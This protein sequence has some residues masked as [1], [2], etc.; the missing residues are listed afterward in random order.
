MNSRSFWV[1]TRSDEIAIDQGCYFDISAADRVRKFF[2]KFLR[3]SK[4]EWAGKPFELLDWQW[5]HCIAPLFGWK[6][7]NG[8]R[9]FRRAGWGLP[10]KNGKSTLASGISLYTLCGDDEPGAEVYS[11]AADRDQASIIYNEAAA[12]VEAS[13]ALSAYIEIVR[14]QKRMTF[15]RLNGAYKALSADVPTKEGLNIHCLLFDELHAQKTWDLWNTLRYGGAA[16]KQPLLV[17]I[18]TA[19]ADKQSLCGVQ[20]QYALN[21]QTG[22]IIDIH[23]LPYIAAADDTDDWTQPET[24]EKAN[25][26]YG[27]TLNPQD[28]AQDCKEAQQ[29]AVQENSFKR[30]RLNLWT[31]Q[32][33]RWIQLSKWDACYE[34]Y[35]EDDLA[36]Q[37]CRIGVDL[38]S[39][40][41][42]AAAV[43]VFKQGSR[44]RIVPRFW[45]PRERLRVRELEN[46]TRLDQWVH[47]G[48][49]TAT[50]GD[51]IDYNVIRKDLGDLATRFKVEEV[52]IDPWNATQF[53]TDL[54]GD[55]FPVTYVRTGFLSVSAA[56][57][58]YEKLVLARELRHN[59][60]PVMDWM[61][62]N[63]AVET[64]A[65]GNL[66]PS[67]KKSSEKID[68]AVATIL[69]LARFI[70]QP[71]KKASK[72]ETQTLSGV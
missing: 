23:F 16:R 20:W 42:I 33:T 44:Y 25:P 1:R 29:S 18:S 2:A 54:Q 19:G 53:A 49:I 60:N 4:G 24:W 17:W 9:R 35:S 21:V 15:P 66:K 59:A 52:C 64:D 65:S 72:Y 32:V 68:G 7:A 46:L 30:Y 13:P 43:L 34:D 51:V 40:T 58:E 5:E 47:D 45:V 31:S 10:K 48:Y 57:K 56:T 27:I 69:A 12:M 6:Q 8:T 28:F 50:D 26:S 67:K 63:I 14:S 71:K 11:A 61:V 38:A 39:T 22:H 37:P 36:G 41:D 70:S 62:N 3:H 55:G